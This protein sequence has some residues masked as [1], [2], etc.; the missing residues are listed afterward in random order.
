M[1]A[2][3]SMKFLGDI[4]LEFRDFKNALLT[5]KRLKSFCDDRRHYREKIVCYG[6]LGLVHSL[7]DNFNQAIKFYHKQLELAWE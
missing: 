3:T 4:Y 5:Y 7:L 6:Q 1:L 2:Y